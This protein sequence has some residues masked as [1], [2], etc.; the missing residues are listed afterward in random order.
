MIQVFQLVLD[1]WGNLWVRLV[2]L[3]FPRK[4]KGEAKFI[5]PGNSP[6]LID[7]LDDFGADELEQL[8]RS[9]ELERLP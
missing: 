4:E 9:Y 2:E 5:K 3:K 1:I 7:M 6:V 8:H